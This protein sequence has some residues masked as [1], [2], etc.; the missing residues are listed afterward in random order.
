[1]FPLW[2]SCCIFH[3]PR[4]IQVL[5][6]GLALR[7]AIVHLEPMRKDWAGAPSSVTIWMSWK[8]GCPCTPGSCWWWL[9]TTC[10]PI[11]LIQIKIGSIS[12]HPGWQ[13]TSM[14]SWI[15]MDICDYLCIMMA[16]K[17][18]FI[19]VDSSQIISNHMIAKDTLIHMDTCWTCEIW[20][21][22]TGNPHLC[23]N[24]PR[25]R[26]LVAAVSWSIAQ[27]SLLTSQRSLK[28][29]VP[30]SQAA[31]RSH[32]GTKTHNSQQ[33]V[34]KSHQ[35]AE[36]MKIRISGSFRFMFIVFFLLL[37]LLIRFE[38]FCIGNWCRECLV[39]EALGT[40]NFPITNH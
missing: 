14:Y 21:K 10:M 23:L 9:L 2:C 27:L 12:S 13:S 24:P 30:E 17:Q 5:L 32:H 16:L 40:S 22:T 36:G 39:S 1:M 34:S 15:S 33:T 19:D 31:T 26:S 11:L 35:N 28:R 25:V 29:L 6:F 20:R 38:V 37:A 18:Q 7:I 8:T 3:L 4:R